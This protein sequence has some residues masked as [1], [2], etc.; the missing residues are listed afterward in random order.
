MQRIT[1]PDT[2]VGK[3]PEGT[4]IL[5]TQS[6]GG[7]EKGARSPGSM[8][9]ILHNAGALAKARV[10]SAGQGACLRQRK[11]GTD[12]KAKGALKGQP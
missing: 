12:K 1:I 2:G 5:A 4:W 8:P 3:S 6:S 7:Q 10:S 11:S 9:G